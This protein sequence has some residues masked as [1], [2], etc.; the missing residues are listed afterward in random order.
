MISCKKSGYGGFMAHYTVAQS[1]HYHQSP[2]NVSLGV[3]ALIDPLRWPGAVNLSPFKSMHYTQLLLGGDPIGIRI[4]KPQGTET[5][6]L[7]EL[8]E[9]HKNLAKKHCA[10]HI[11]DSKELDIPAEILNMNEEGVDVIFDPVGIKIALN[12]V[13]PACRVHGIFIKLAVWG[14][15]PSLDVNDLAY[16][17]I[18]YMGLLCMMRCPSKRGRG[19]ELW[20]ASNYGVPRIM[21]SSSTI[22]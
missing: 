8:M 20:C 4:L 11:F 17:E 22:N 12:G 19:T 10:T 3:G 6:I 18:N 1:E 14:A 13:I 5:I 2:E 9:N 21:V 15:R 7:V 16:N